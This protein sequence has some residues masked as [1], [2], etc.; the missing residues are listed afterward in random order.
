MVLEFHLLSI[1][2]NNCISKDSPSSIDGFPKLENTFYLGV[3]QPQCT[4][5]QQNRPG[6]CWSV[7][8][9]SLFCCCCCCCGPSRDCHVGISYLLQSSG[10]K[11][12]FTLKSPA[13][14]CIMRNFFFCPLSFCLLNKSYTQLS[15]LETALLPYKQICNCHL[16]RKK[17][18]VFKA[19]A[20]SLGQHKQLETTLPPLHLKNKKQHLGNVTAITP[21]NHNHAII[22]R[23]ALLYVLV[24]VKAITLQVYRPKT[25]RLMCSMPVKPFDQG[26]YYIH[27]VPYNFC[28]CVFIRVHSFSRLVFQSPLLPC[29]QL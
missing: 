18:S 16:K 12:A 7:W 15:P 2:G 3:C 26:M 21:T 25:G 28:V 13:V 22:I 1:T 9:N 10:I 11:M 14:S 27:N 23:A 4:M 8:C 20:H 17:F 5:V 24:G 19:F 29:L 6:H